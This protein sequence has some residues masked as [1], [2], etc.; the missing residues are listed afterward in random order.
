[1]TESSFQSS[2][3]KILQADI[4]ST[5]LDGY[6]VSLANRIGGF[7]FY[8][9]L[10]KPYI[11]GNI[12]ILD[13]ANIL[14]DINFSGTET[15][16]LR[17]SGIGTVLEDYLDF[18]FIVDRV[19]K[20]YRLN[21]RTLVY[22]LSLVDQT[23]YLDASNRFSKSYSGK[24]ENI[25]TNICSSELGKTVDVTPSACVQPKVKMIVPYLTALQACNWI[26]SKMTTSNGSPWYLFAHIQHK[27]LLLVDLDTLL[28]ANPVNAQP[29]IYSIASTAKAAS[30]DPKKQSNLILSVQQSN[31]ENTLSSVQRGFLSSIISTTDVA[32][33]Q[34]TMHNYSVRTTLDKLKR[35]N[36]IKP[37]Y[38]Q[39]VFD[40]H[41]T[42][43]HS[44]K[45]A[46]QPDYYNSR[47]FHTISSG[48]TYPDINNIS[49]TKDGAEL[50]NEL[51][52]ASIRDILFKN[53]INIEMWG[54]EIFAQKISVGNI[55]R[56]QFLSSSS[57]RN[58]LGIDEMLDENRSGDYL[59]YAMA[60]SF[61]MEK[62]KVSMSIVKLTKNP[63][64]Q[65]YD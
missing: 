37:G 32:S 2:H 58:P 5:R 3:Y 64:S 16:K 46:K 4:S 34:T 44:V 48:K 23:G 61:D 14:D 45:G 8:E 30:G 65:S 25:I 21:E 49:A 17:V 60:H 63:V 38:E 6:F 10:D 29:Y 28:S 50:N 15:L 56:V 53:S 13:D 20:T 40:T 41:Q 7:T 36:V 9:H 55:I 39:N 1:M 59:I 52:R 12:V 35:S 57:Q 51:S 42:L 26:K 22:V 54:H 33:G 62:H 18:T 31:M 27:N 43:D 47:Y 19:L 24:L 11:T